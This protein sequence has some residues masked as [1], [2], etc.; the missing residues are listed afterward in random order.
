MT[1]LPLSLVLLWVGG[2]NNNDTILFFSIAAFAFLILSLLCQ[3][4]PVL[5]KVYLCTHLDAILFHVPFEKKFFFSQKKTR[6]LWLDY[7]VCPAAS[8]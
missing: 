1:A 6:A 5:S 8:R 4:K 3:L 2:S 7:V